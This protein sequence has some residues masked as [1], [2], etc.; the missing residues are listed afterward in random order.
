MSHASCALVAGI[1]AW[2]TDES[3]SHCTSFFW[4]VSY[5]PLG[6]PVNKEQAAVQRTRESL[7]ELQIAVAVRIHRRCE[8]RPKRDT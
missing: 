3:E 7:R 4:L 6:E 5:I 1:D 8:L 2:R